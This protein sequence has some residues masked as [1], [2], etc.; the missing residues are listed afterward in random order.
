MNTHAL[1]YSFICTVYVAIAIPVLLMVIKEP[2]ADGLLAMLNSAIFSVPLLSTFLTGYL[3]FRSRKISPWLLGLGHFLVAHLLAFVRYYM[4]AAWHAI[5]AARGEPFTLALDKV[6][7]ATLV[8]MIGGLWILPG[9]M[10]LAWLLRK[11]YLAS[12]A[13]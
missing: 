6:R 10:V 13:G 1:L 8:S 5:T 9:F 3:C 2:G 11:R 12:E 4:L 7:E